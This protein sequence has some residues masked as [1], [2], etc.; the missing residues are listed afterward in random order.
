MSDELIIQA[1]SSY[2]I[3]GEGLF[4]LEG[5]PEKNDLRI[6]PADEAFKNNLNCFTWDINTGYIFLGIFLE[7]KLAQDYLN[8]IQ[9]DRDKDVLFQSESLFVLEGN[10][11]ENEM[12]IM[13]ADQAFKT[14]LVHFELGIATGY[15]YM[16]V[17]TSEQLAHD[18]IALIR[19]GLRNEEGTRL[20]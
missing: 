15:Q 6:L 14:N 5:N 18:H 8:A 4:I 10:P 1:F 13:L 2:P 7:E 12:R 19:R 20:V 9:S 17:F 3:L 16:G 11:R